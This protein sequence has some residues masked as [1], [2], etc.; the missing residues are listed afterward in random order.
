MVSDDSH[1]QWTANWSRLQGY[2]LKIGMD[3]WGFMS[4][5]YTPST[6]YLVDHA[7]GQEFQQR[8]RLLINQQLTNQTIL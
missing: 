8:H 3:V 5:E 4:Q 6:M 2:P 1:Y 7:N